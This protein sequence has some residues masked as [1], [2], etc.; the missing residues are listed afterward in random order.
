MIY[1]EAGGSYFGSGPFVIQSEGEG[2]LRLLRRHPLP[3]RIND[4]RLVAYDSP[5]E[6][7][8][9]T[10][11]GDAN[12]VL[13]LDPRAVEFFNGVKSLQVIRGGGHSTDSILFNVDMPREERVQLARYLASDRVRELAY[14]EGDCAESGKASAGDIPLPRGKKLDVLT[15]GSFERLALAVRRALGDRGGDVVT[16]SP[17]QVLAH[18]R[19]RR[20]DLVTAR[21]LMW[22]RNMLAL[23]WASGSPENAFGYSNPLVDRAVEAG[24]WDAA[25]RALQADPPGAFICTRQHLAV[26]DSRIK[27]PE[28][29]PYDLLQTLP[30]WEVAQ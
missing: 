21:P 5:R 30:D 24:D 17:Q 16:E 10:L 29:G 22:P 13:D 19:E 3:N 18:V 26:V 1:K 9:R 2:E 6:A 4:V 8:T 27:N 25:E 20:F 15:W 28:L 23:S 11:K 12:L 14:G 7:F